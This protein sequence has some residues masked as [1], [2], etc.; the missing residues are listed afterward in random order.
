VMVGNFPSHVRAQELAAYLQKSLGIV[1]RCKVKRVYGNTPPHAFV[2]FMSAA[3]A[4][5]AC[6]E[7]DRGRLNFQGCELRIAPCTV[8]AKSKLSNEGILSFF[9]SYYVE[10]DVLQVPYYHI[11]FSLGSESMC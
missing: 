5:E 1:D 2:Q 10:S 9:T 4:R 3:V 8:Q 7:S 6:S 11:F